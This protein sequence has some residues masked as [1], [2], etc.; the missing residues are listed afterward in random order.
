MIVFMGR[1]LKPV[2]FQS[3]TDRGAPEF[4]L[5]RPKRLYESRIIS[6]VELRAVCYTSGPIYRISRLICFSEIISVRYATPLKSLF[7]Y[8][9]LIV[10]VILPPVTA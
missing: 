9:L 10:Y 3:L 1:C 5:T 2:M 8:Q 6:I 4:V 7:R